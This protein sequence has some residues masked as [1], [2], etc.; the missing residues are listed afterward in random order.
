MMEAR[1]REELIRQVTKARSHLGREDLE[2]LAPLMSTLEA[3]TSVDPT[4]VQSLHRGLSTLYG[5]E[6]ADFLCLD[7][8]GLHDIA[9][10]FASFFRAWVLGEIAQSPRILKINK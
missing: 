2:I 6:V 3:S 7:A 8:E 5:D 10:R 4:H 9:T 1:D